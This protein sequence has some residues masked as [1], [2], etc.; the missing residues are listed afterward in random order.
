MTTNHRERLD[1]ALLRPSRADY[2][3]FL[4]NASY[5]QM[6]RLFLRL[7]PEKE[8]LAHQF[9]IQLPERKVSMA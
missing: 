4:D 3:A 1:P 7:N 2:H 8:E 5:D 6:K 9:A